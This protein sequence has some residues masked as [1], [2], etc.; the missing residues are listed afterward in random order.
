MHDVIIVAAKRT[1][2]G[3]FGG[4]LSG[5]PASDLGAAVIKTLICDS[6]IAPESI[7]DVILSH[8]L[9][10]AAGQNSARQVALSGGLPNTRPALTIND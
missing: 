7:D 3:S 8:V 4:T 1:P 9:T 10:A 5:L 6:G 2:V